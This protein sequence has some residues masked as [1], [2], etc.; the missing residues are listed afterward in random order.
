MTLL[1]GQYGP[2]GIEA[3]D[4]KHAIN[5]PVT[6]LDSNGDP[7]V[8]YADRHKSALAVNPTFT[9]SFGNLLFWADPGYYSMS[10]GNSQALQNVVVYPDPLEP[11]SLPPGL[12]DSDLTVERLTATTL[13]GHSCV[14]TDDI[15]ALVYADCSDTSQVSRPFW[16]TTGAWSS[17][18]LAQVLIEGVVTEPSWNWIVGNP[19][20]LGLNGQL[21]Q[22]IPPEA[23][24]IRQLAEV[25]EPNT[26]AFRANQPIVLA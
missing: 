17:G 4:G 14:T 11:P 26:I 6:V 22:S 7:A 25:I 16:M 8:L 2:D 18:V 21:T 9:D 3:P 1:A 5:T 23:V 12:A 13:S 24:F 19:I 10:V 20:W 15:G